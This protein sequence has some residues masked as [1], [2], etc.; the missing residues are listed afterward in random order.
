MF[1]VEIVIHAIGALC[2]GDVAKTA[3][4]SGGNAGGRLVSGEPADGRSEVWTNWLGSAPL[5]T[6]MVWVGYTTSPAKLVSRYCGRA[7]GI[8]YW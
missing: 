8:A 1:R 3:L 2:G 7:L 4:L 5:G 6:L